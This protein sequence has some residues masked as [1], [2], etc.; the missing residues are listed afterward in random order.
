MATKEEKI[1]VDGTVEEALKGNKFMVRLDNDHAVIGY[2]SGK[3]RRYF[4]RVLL[5]DRVTLELS[6][7]DMDRG[8]I[9]FRYRRDQR[10]PTHQPS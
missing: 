10:I 1:R 7:Y 2:L 4:I 3:M 8:R 6:P 9:V 5:G